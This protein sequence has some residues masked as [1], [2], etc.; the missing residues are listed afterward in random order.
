M[1]EDV[2]ALLKQASEGLLYPSESD[3]PFEAFMW[4]STGADAAKEVAARVPKGAK[5][6][7]QS[8]DAFFAELEQGDGADRFVKLRHVLESSLKEA[9]VYRVG[10]VEV[11]VYILGKLGPRQ[12]AG[13]RTK[14][15]E[16]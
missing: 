7:E 12:W 14:S 8:L 6:Q 15:I 13:I 9:K 2:L 11:D 16:T 4:N 3:E 10:E 1:A 5:I